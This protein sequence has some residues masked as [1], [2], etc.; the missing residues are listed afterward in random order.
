M[1]DGDCF[2]LP[3]TQEVLADALGLTSVHV[4]RTLQRLRSGGFIELSGGDLT[5]LNGLQKLAGSDS[6]YLHRGRL[7]RR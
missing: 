6:N 1:F 3:M 4:N 7:S 5:T 2:E